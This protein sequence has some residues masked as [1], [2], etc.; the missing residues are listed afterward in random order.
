M[1]AI[2]DAFGLFKNH[3]ELR[4]YLWQPLLISVPAYI[5]IWALTAWLVLPPLQGLATRFN[6]PWWLGNLVFML[7]WFFIGGTVFITVATM[8]SGQFWESLNKRVEEIEVGKVESARL[9]MVRANLD[10]MARTFF[11]LMMLG[12]GAVLGWI[13][14]VVGPLLFV[15]FVAALDFTTPAMARRGYTLRPH[16]AKVAAIKDILPFAVVAGFAS[17]FPFV[18]VLMLPILVAAGTLTVV[19]HEKAKGPLALPSGR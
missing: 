7:L 12:C 1:Q 6:L 4:K 17:G 11:S 8:L 18:N 9:G 13:I 10:G 5:A 3:R 19:R 2:R 14:P 15:A 16:I